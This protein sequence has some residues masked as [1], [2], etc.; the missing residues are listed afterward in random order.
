MGPNPS[1]RVTRDGMAPR[2]AAVYLVPR[3]AVPFQAPHLRPWVAQHVHVTT[4]HHVDVV[5]RDSDGQYDHSY[6]LDISVFTSKFCALRSA[7]APSAR[8]SLCCGRDAPQQRPSSAAT[9]HVA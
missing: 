8:S 3:G 7:P 5:D 2:G 1:V 6:E 4:S 9:T